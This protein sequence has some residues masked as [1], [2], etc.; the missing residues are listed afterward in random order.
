MAKKLNKKVLTILLAF[1]G[2]CIIGAGFVG[3]RYLRDRD[4]DRC[5]TLA[6]QA[7]ENK[8]FQDAEGYYGKAFGYNKID[9]QKKD[10]LFEIAEFHLIEDP[11]HEANWRKAL[12]CWNQITTID[13]DNVLSRRKLMDYF[14]TMADT[15]GDPMAWK[16]VEEQSAKLLAIFKK[17]AQP[18][19]VSVL[20]ANARANVELV[21]HGG[22][23][24]PQEN[25]D[26][27]R[28]I[29][30]SLKLQKP[31]DVNIYR[32]LADLAMVQGELDDTK[33]IADARQTALASAKAI[34]QEATIAASDKGTAAA[35][36]LQTRLSEAQQDPNLL[37]PLREEIRKQTEL[38]HESDKLWAVLSTSYDLHGKMNR[39]DEIN[40]AIAA[41]EKSIQAAPDNVNYQLRLAILKNRLGNLLQDPTL[42]DQAIAAA[43]AAMHLPDVQSA[44]G[45]KEY[46]GTQNRFAI[47]TYLARMYTDRT[48]ALQQQK[49]DA[50][51]APYKSKALG[52][53]RQLSQMAG[54]PDNIVA[55]QWDGIKSLLEG[56]EQEALRTLNKAY[57]QAKTQDR[58]DQVSTIDSYLCYTL[59]TLAGKQGQTGL[60]REFFE[61]AL[62]NQNSIAIDKPQTILDYADTMITL[63]AAAS[64]ISALDSYV[65]IYGQTD[66]TQQIKV[67]ALIAAQE[68]AAAKKVLDRMDEQNTTTAELKLTANYYILN[69]LLAMQ[70]APGQDASE[71]DTTKINATRAAISQLLQNLIGQ[72]SPNLD[73]QMVAFICRDMIGQDKL[74]EAVS[75]V[76]AYLA[77]NPGD[78]LLEFLK[79]Q[80]QQP[81]P[82]NISLEKR[83]ELYETAIRAIKDPVKRSLALS[84]YF[85]SNNQKDQASQELEAAYKEHP[86]KPELITTLLAFYTENKRIKEAEDLFSKTRSL[87][88]DGCDGNLM[89][90]QLEIAKE[91]YPAALRRLDECLVIK[92][93]M[94]YAMLLKSQVYG[95][96]KDW[97]QA[98]ETIRK[99]QAIEPLDGTIAR[100]A[101]SVYF[102]RNRELG[103][104][105][106]PDQ[107]LET[108]RAVGLA[109]MLNPT[110][111]QLQN[112]YAEIISLRDPDKA[113]ATQQEMLKNNPTATNALLLGSMAMRQALQQTDN[114]KRG[115]LLE[116]AGSAFAQ[117]YQMEPAN[118]Q[119]AASYAEFFR[120]TN[121]PQKAQETF[122]DN[123]EALWR[124]Y[125]SAGQYDKAA[126][127]LDKLYT[128]KQK[129]ADIVEG[130]A[131]TAEG[132]GQRDKM[133][134]YLDTLAQIELTPE[135]NLR[136]IQKFLD[137]GLQQSAQKE[138]EA[139]RASQ[140]NDARALLFQ[141][142]IEMSNGKLDDA[143]KLCS[144]FTDAN[145][146]DAG[147][148]RL[149]GRLYR[150]L[151]RPEEAI[152][153]FQRSLSIKP[154]PTVRMEL[155][156][157]YS[158]NGHKDVAIGELV[159][160]LNDPR[161]PLQMY[162]MLE[163]L[164]ARDKRTPD[165]VRFFDNLLKRYPQDVFFHTR[166]GLFY[167]QQKNYP[168]ALELLEKAWTLS[169]TGS[170]GNPAAL[171]NYIQALSAAG[172]HD[173][174]M[175]IAAKYIDSPIGV[176]AYVQM[177]I[178]QSQ[179]GQREKSLEYF[180]KAIEK[181]AN[182]QSYVYTCLENMRKALGDE[183]VQVWCKEKIAARTGYIPA[184]L[185]LA[186]LAE[187]D[188]QY[189]Q[190][191]AHIDECLKTAPV[192]SPVWLE[193]LTRKSNTLLMA[194]SKTED[195]AY[196][197]QA[198][199]PLKAILEKQPDNLSVMNNMAFMFADAGQQLDTAEQYARKVYQAAPDNPV[200]ID[201]YAFVLCK[202]GQYAQAEPYLLQA[203]Q[204]FELNS[205]PIPWDTYRHLGMAYEGQ[206][207]NEL[208][209]DAY[210]KAIALPDIP[211]QKKNELTKKL[212][213]L[214]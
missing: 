73:S 87:N 195:K 162:T 188:G 101:A 198:I 68:Y 149:K 143:M 89:A 47:L 111:T 129:D 199:E 210:Q 35:Y 54:S 206:Q 96:Q 99:A 200:F 20:L 148:W 124:F 110:D 27:A 103:N 71:S 116:I 107:L 33:K 74:S 207:K 205:D 211:I 131:L 175:A 64:A 59:A 192:N 2:V 132:L 170:S 25:I 163:Q 137:A 8:N 80:T 151:S 62:F 79:L 114:A 28:A 156:I 145:P 78:T 150:Y 44:R 3:V 86:D 6:R 123:P 181:A 90:A 168:R 115:A 144:Q 161:P 94:T 32:Y 109:M 126:P 51:A 58:P 157:V 92:P 108:E 113:I 158:Q 130:L 75:L 118:T 41:T 7:K 81:D 187:Q 134:Q 36:Y 11:Q 46:I 30:D 152:S 119:I 55:L 1:L 174:A 178:L 105:T 128:E 12:G 173:A 193:L 83:K 98:T 102:Q 57:Q 191:A 171:E 45:P 142:W 18:E 203:I 154:D 179:I 52:S 67:R 60:R 9:Q 189:N 31:D 117:A 42:T 209:R 49:D 136:L 40:A 202:K 212:Q 21:R 19:D 17:T 125:L 122:K 13:P 63:R 159:N 186:F 167:L 77:Y 138:L 43:Q 10:I 53:I 185:M 39:Q 106:T 34:L 85:L 112:V 84:Q 70:T 197:N 104:K 176:A 61:K 29:L 121:Q 127:I 100:Q 26:K 139:F 140:P 204:L 194:Y 213:E 48:L 56:K 95:L 177:G 14:Y 91:N 141:A 69:Q 165:L 82:K 135:Q 196:F 208:A 23:T 37:E 180:I 166:A 93:T 155:A 201:T 169:S 5:L 24:N 88:P 50:A 147:A 214:Q 153:A 97:A 66:R 172:Q 133:K 72:K 183:P 160:G 182:N 38:Y 4:P 190:A 22:V 15:S 146:N 76:D 164:Y 184:R 65:A 120:L 16:S